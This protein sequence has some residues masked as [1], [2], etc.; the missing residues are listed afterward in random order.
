MG[1][2]ALPTVDSEAFISGRTCSE[3]KSKSPGLRPRFFAFFLGAEAPGSLR[4]RRCAT[5]V[6]GEERED[7]GASYR[8]ILACESQ[9]AC[10]A[11]APEQRNGVAFLIAYINEISARVDAEMA[12]IVAQ[13]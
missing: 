10:V 5:V 8:R 4:K 13:G 7:S 1:H 2:G 11:V 6:L 9:Q 12:G 3:R